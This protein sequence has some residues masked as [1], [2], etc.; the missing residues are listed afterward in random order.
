MMKEY[1]NAVLINKSAATFGEQPVYRM[2]FQTPK[3]ICSFRV[4]RDAY[5]AG[6]IG[7]KGTL[8]FAGNRMESFG[9][10]H[11]SCSQTVTERSWL[12]LQA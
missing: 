1:L 3:G 8:V 7:E 12:R 4:A 6:R 2:V 5:N 9:T 10:I 11:N